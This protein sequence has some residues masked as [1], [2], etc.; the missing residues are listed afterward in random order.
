MKRIYYVY[1][2]LNGEYA[3]LLYAQ[4]TGRLLGWREALTEQ[5]SSC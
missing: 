1:R 5:S 4:K 3:I 2:K